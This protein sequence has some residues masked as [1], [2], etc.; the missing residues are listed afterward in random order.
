[1]SPSPA[2][3]Q[4]TLAECILRGER[5]PLESWIAVPDGVDPDPSANRASKEKGSYYEAN[6]D[7]GEEAAHSRRA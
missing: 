5:A 4:R 1:M 2:E 6:E 7:Q 3:L